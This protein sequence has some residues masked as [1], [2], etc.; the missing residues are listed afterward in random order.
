MEGWPVECTFDLSETQVQLLLD[1]LARER[2]ELTDEILHTDKRA[3][4]QKLHERL[5]N[6]DRLSERLKAQVKTP[7]AQI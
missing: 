7:V 2:H 5:D 3:Y 6:V 4:R 1:V